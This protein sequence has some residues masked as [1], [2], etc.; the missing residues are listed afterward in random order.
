MGVTN[1]V[2]Q[3]LAELERLKITGRPFRQALYHPGP[4]GGLPQARPAGLGIISHFQFWQGP[5][6]RAQLKQSTG[7]R[8]AAVAV[9][10][11]GQSKRLLLDSLQL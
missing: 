10:L 1:A 8:K 7:Q 9:Q 5:N 3:T 2:V 6:S 4:T 11:P